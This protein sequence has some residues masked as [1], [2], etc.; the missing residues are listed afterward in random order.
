MSIQFNDFFL[1]RWLSEK[2]GGGDE[3]LTEYEV[4]AEDA[5]A[6]LFPFFTILLGVFSYLIL[7]RYFPQFPY[8]ALM[9]LLGMVM[10]LL[11]QNRT[12]YH[13]VQ[14]I[15]MWEGIGG[16]L[17]LLVFLP[18]LIFKDAFE[19]NFYLFVKAS[20]QVFIFAFPMVLGGT[21]LVALVAYKIFP[22]GWTWNQSMTF[23]SI[24]AATDPVAVAA[25]MN[26]VG[27]PP[28]LK[29]HIS[30]ESIFNDG[31]AIVFYTIFS[32]LVLN[33]F[34]FHLVDIDV[35]KGFGMF[36]KLSFGAAAIG[37]TSG[38]FLVCLF[39]IFNRHLSSEESIVEVTATIV[40][41]Y[42]TYYIADPVCGTSGV[43]ATCTMAIT[44]RALGDGMI[45]DHRLMENYWALTEHLLNTVLFTL[46]GVVW[47]NLISDSKQ[48]TFDGES[49]WGLREWGYLILLWVFL[50]LIRGFLFFSFYP[51]TSRIGLK[52]N[53]KETLFSAWGGL[54]GAVGI[55]LGLS[56][57]NEVLAKTD[58]PETIVITSRM[59]GMI[60]GIA[61]MTLVINGTSCGPILKKL[62][63]VTCT[64]AR[65]KILSC[66]EKERK[67]FLIEN[68]VDMISHGRFSWLDFKFIRKYIPAMRELTFDELRSAIIKHKEKTPAKAYKKPNLRTIFP[69][70]KCTP[71]ELLEL[72]EILHST[73]DED[74]V[75]IDLTEKES[76]NSQDDILMNFM[77]SFSAENTLKSAENTLKKS[78][79]NVEPELLKAMRLL[80][81]E[82]IKST[83][84]ELEAKGDINPRALGGFLVYNLHY[85]LE[86]A[87]DK[88]N[89][90]EKLNDWEELQFSWKN[91]IGTLFKDVRRLRY[92]KQHR[93]NQ[94]VRLEI[95]RTTSYLKAHH[96]AQRRMAEQF[97]MN[98]AGFAC[99]AVLKESMEG[100]QKA[101]NFF[102]NYDLN[103][104]INVLSRHAASVLL[105]RDVLKI[106]EFSKDGVYSSKE[107]QEYLEEMQELINEVNHSYHES[108]DEIET[109]N[110]NDKVKER[111]ASVNEYMKKNSQVKSVEE[112][113]KSFR[114]SSI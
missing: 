54:R 17:L 77:C 106:T 70:L 52:T 87:K 104:V 91:P 62:G 47:G 30:A 55:S 49:F 109:T 83:Y 45:N 60:G 19:L 53:L 108:F 100:V 73:G 63:L 85:S 76:M 34:G 95:L 107:A 64:E 84:K 80:F 36:F 15:Q 61:L 6:V 33:E 10:G 94:K 16:E 22:Y 27:A 90:G 12:D 103:V 23:G 5:W 99:R 113:T 97:Q 71:D 111:H 114:L 110:A 41:A 75:E 18:A 37:I 89:H 31:S 92:T 8:T 13:I 40:F 32:N 46:A 66:I 88:A 3:T 65:K 86:T 96:K 102:N 81:I 112:I 50:V 51:I 39:Y 59:F 58:N 43:I 28:R 82:F 68:L 35:A 48:S 98:E 74:T 4:E 7:T 20:V 69:Y 14:S 26:E 72:V 101:I 78:M 25:L 21:C 2:E 56:L 79:T 24:L 9:F 105:N 57:H 29:M 1:W 67:M 42:L 93:Q 44:A 38:F 11:T